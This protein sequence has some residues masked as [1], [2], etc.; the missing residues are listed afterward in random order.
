MNKVLIVH[1]MLT[2]AFA[3]RY[4]DSRDRE[5]IKNAFDDLFFGPEGQLKKIID[6]ILLQIAS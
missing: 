6:T 1:N 5:L 2:I 4:P 3:S